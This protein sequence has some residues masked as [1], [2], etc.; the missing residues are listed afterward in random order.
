MAD[1]LQKCGLVPVHLLD[2]FHVPLQVLARLQEQ[3]IALTLQ[4]TDAVAQRQGQHHHHPQGTEMG[5][6][7]DHR[8]IGN[9]IQVAEHEEKDQ[10]QK[11]APGRHIQPRRPVAAR[12]HHPAQ[13]AE[14][15]HRDQHQQ[16]GQ[17]IGPG[18]R[19]QQL[20]HQQHGDTR[21]VV[22]DH[23]VIAREALLEAE[24]VARV[25]GQRRRADIDA[26]PVVLIEPGHLRPNELQPEAVDVQVEHRDAHQEQH[27]I[28][29]DRLLERQRQQRVVDHH[30]QQAAVE[31]PVQ[32]DVPVGV[33]HQPGGAVEH[34]RQIDGALAA[35]AHI[36]GVGTG[37]VG[38]EGKDKGAVVHQALIE[39]QRVAQVH[40]PV[41][42]VFS[43]REQ[44]DMV[45]DRIA[46]HQVP[47]LP[48]DTAGIQGEAQPDGAAGEA[49]IGLGGGVADEA[50][51]KTVAHLAEIPVPF[52]VHQHLHGTGHGHL[53]LV[54]LR[55]HHRLGAGQRAPQQ[56]YA[57]Q[58]I[59]EL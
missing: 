24:E 52:R 9:P 41:A 42:A 43:G 20:H 34:R 46:F 49:E 39:R 25:H 22:A 7:A 2:L 33:F 53:L 29:V 12:P 54:R 17:V 32:Q 44:A 6:H 36:V 15:Q 40:P 38:V 23:P 51:G 45:E 59:T 11:H 18:R 5:Q 21:Q 30:D 16:R 3:L 50:A 57:N 13:P 48:P 26:Q 14:Q 27:E 37:Q 19:D 4:E 58:E 35:D 55:R 1:V 28:Q 8:G 47:A 31:H 10:H 56:P